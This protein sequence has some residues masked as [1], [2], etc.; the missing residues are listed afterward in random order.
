MEAWKAIWPEG[1]VDCADSVG[2]G[3]TRD[4]WTREM[5]GMA[6]EGL[7][8]YGYYGADGRKVVG[9][10]GSRAGHQRSSPESELPSCLRCQLEF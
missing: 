7:M 2:C 6:G 10:L 1:C 5:V 4:Q 3:Y 8:V 9:V